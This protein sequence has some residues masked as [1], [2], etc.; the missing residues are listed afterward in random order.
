MLPTQKTCFLPS[1]WNVSHL[2]EDVQSEVELAGWKPGE[3]MGN[4]SSKLPWGHNVSLQETCVKI[5]HKCMQAQ[6]FRD[7]RAAYMIWLRLFRHTSNDN[8]Q[9]HQEHNRVFSLNLLPVCVTKWAGSVPFKFVLVVGLQFLPES[10][11]H[12]SDSGCVCCQPVCISTL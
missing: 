12:L 6:T 9:K 3:L 5:N 1:P 4:F 11:G 8:T 10:D 2:S 7:R